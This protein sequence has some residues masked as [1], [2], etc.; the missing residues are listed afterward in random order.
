MTVRARL[1]TASEAF[2]GGDHPAVVAALRPIL[3]DPARWAAL[4]RADGAA[5]VGVAYMGGVSR[6]VVGDP[7]GAAAWLGLVAGDGDVPPHVRRALAQ[8]ELARGELAAA[9][10]LLDDGEHAAPADRALSMIAAFRAGHADDAARLADD[11]ER[12]LEAGTGT[13]GRA[14]D[15][16]GIRAQVGL[17]QV[18]LRDAA[19]AA[20]AADAIA[21]LAEGAPATLPLAAHE[22]VIRA[23]ALRL[24]GDLDAA[25]AIL[26]DAR[27]SLGGKLRSRPRGARA[28]ARAACPGARRARTRRLPRRDA[29]VRGGGRALARGRDGAGGGR[30]LTRARARG[31]P[32]PA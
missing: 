25:A 30:R 6:L 4:G 27:A 16:A 28:R 9:R 1:R 24:S 17:V 3:D 18:E 26:D 12:E 13:G 23:G 19:R 10:A 32:W 20:R 21:Q 8:V 14:L 11:L 5:A 31:V 15:Q 29:N 7:D 2:E 22:R